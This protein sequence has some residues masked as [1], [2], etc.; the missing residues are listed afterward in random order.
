MV[1]KDGKATT[2]ATFSAPGT[3]VIRAFADDGVLFE[4]GDVTVT[5][6]PKAPNK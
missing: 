4:G 5:V 2:Q 3:Y 1:V 6:A